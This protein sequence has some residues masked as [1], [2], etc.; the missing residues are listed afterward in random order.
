M[1][2]LSEQG[3]SKLVDD[4]YPNSDAQMCMRALDGAKYFSQIDLNNAYH[5]VALHPDSQHYTAFV[6]PTGRHMK[7]QCVPFGM[8]MSDAAFL[9]VLDLVTAGLKY[10]DFVSF[11][12]DIIVFGK[13]V[14]Q[15]NKRLNRLLKRFS[16]S[17]VTISAKKCAFGT[18]GIT[19]LGYDISAE[20]I[21]LSLA[22]VNKIDDIPVSTTVTD[23]RALLGT[24]QY[25]RKH[26]PNLGHLVTPIVQLLRKDAKVK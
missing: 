7:Y 6:T 15:H 23:I 2:G 11:V 21:R 12:D 26:I 16:E 24:I 5:Q 19:F 9:R 10:K 20:G 18:K 3:C 14:S 22:L 8:K 17:N 13:S 4:S 25:V 1:G